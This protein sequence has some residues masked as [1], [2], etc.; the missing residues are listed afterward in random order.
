MFAI[1]SY[2]SLNLN[3][4]FYWNLYLFSVNLYIIIIIILQLT[5]FALHYY[6]YY[7]FVIILIIFL[8][9][10]LFKFSET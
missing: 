10:S 2:F 6:Y 5:L 4:L 9:H 8:Y 1:V 7:Y 3:N